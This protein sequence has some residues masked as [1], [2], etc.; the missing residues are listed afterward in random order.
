MNCNNCERRDGIS[1]ESC[2]RREA[3]CMSGSEVRVGVGVEVRVGVE[4]SVMIPVGA[5]AEEVVGGSGRRG[6]A[7]GSLRKVR[8]WRRGTSE[9]GI[10][11]V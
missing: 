4:W 1:D 7:I 10:R 3:V 11:S 8:A 6:L 5:T 9:D 2:G